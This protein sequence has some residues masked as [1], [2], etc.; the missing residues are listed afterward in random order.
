MVALSLP[1]RYIQNTFTGIG[2]IVSTSEDYVIML[3]KPSLGLIGT[4]FSN[5]QHSSHSKNQG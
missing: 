3:K 5:G 2:G 1:F 4:I